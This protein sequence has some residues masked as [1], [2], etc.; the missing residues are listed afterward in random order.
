MSTPRPNLLRAWWPAVVW[1]LL[2]AVESTDYLSSDNTGHMLYRLVTRLFGHID[3]AQFLVF[4]H[5][6]RKAGHVF[7]YGI[8][9]LLLLRGLRTTFHEVGVWVWRSALFAWIATAAIASMDEWHQS[10]IPSRMGSPRDVLLDSTAGLIFL[11][12]AYTWF[13]R[14]NGTEQTA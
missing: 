10:F 13:R 8:L 14:S 3:L 6:L 11:L 9:C 4:H 1:I 2:I 12:L 7:G 5:Y